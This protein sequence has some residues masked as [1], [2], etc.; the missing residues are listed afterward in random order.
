MRKKGTTFHTLK[1]VFMNLLCSILFCLHVTAAPIPASDT[2]TNATVIELCKAGLSPDIIK[3]KIKSST[4]SFDVSLNAL[5]ALKKDGVPDDIVNMMIA[6]NAQASSAAAASAASTGIESL[7]SGIYYADSKTH[8][9]VQ[10]EPAVLTNLKS[11]GFG[12][13]LKRAMISGLINA[14][15]RASLSGTEAQLKIPSRSPHF[16]FLFDPAVSGFNNSSVFGSVQSPN[17]FMLVRLEKEKNSREIVIG[18]AN[19]VGSSSGIDDKRKILFASKK[20]QKGIYEVSFDTPLEPGEYCFMFS[21]SSM[22]QGGMKVY[23]FSIR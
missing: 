8:D 1:P 17:E 23:D 16:F 6:T 3:A 22:Y 12:E 20:R 10:L 15:T 21:S 9:Y 4:C 14:K 2:T 13:A 7:S 5:V 18:K 11:G 19:N